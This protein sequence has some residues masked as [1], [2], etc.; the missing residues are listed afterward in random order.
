MFV[1]NFLTAGDYMEIVPIGLPLSLKYDERGVLCGVL[2]GYDNQS[3]DVSN[4]LL[5]VLL[6]NCS[7]VPNSISLKGGTTFV[8]GCLYTAKTFNVSGELPD[9]ISSS[10]LEDFPKHVD[11][12]NFFAATVE[13]YATVFR[14]STS[15]RNWLKLSRFHI[16]PGYTIPSN[17]TEESFEKLVNNETFNFVYPLIA[18]F[19]VFHNDT[20][21]YHDAGLHQA[22]VSSVDTNY[23]VFGRFMSTISFDSDDGDMLVDYS[24]IVAF[25]IYPKTLVVLDNENNIIYSAKTDSRYKKVR[26][27]EIECPVCGRKIH[28]PKYGMVMCSDVHCN[29]RLYSSVVHFLDTH[30]LPAISYD[31]YKQFADTIGNG[32]II[33][34]VLDLP[35]FDST[36]IETTLSEALRSVVPYSIVPVSST[37]LSAISNACN[38][39]ITSLDYYLDHIDRLESDTGVSVPVNL[40]RWL[41]DED[42]RVV[43]NTLLHHDKVKFV[44]TMQKFDG[45]PI[46]RGKRFYLTGEFVHGSHEDVAS[47]L[48]SY[49]GEVVNNYHDEFDCILIGD[50]RENMNGAAIKSA[51][52][53]HLHSFIES[54][55]FKKY[56]IDEDIQTYL[57]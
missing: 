6:N 24:T 25:N 23:D 3:E 9:L 50:T 46:F 41:A 7:S 42:N 48:R 14:G 8:R 18:G 27:S 38:N 1:R 47:I 11:N 55:F 35:Q 12:Y 45:D 28:V 30:R 19:Y 10:I 54:E 33:T 26:E 53:R 29:S 36:V 16:L 20:G 5:G 22:I 43:V 31:E 52:K 32:F 4:Q 39:S 57:G 40:K 13:S 37:S 34:D 21:T 56:Q 17:L 49:A 44:N 15:I 51:A 2:A